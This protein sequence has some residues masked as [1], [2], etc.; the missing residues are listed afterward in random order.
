MRLLLSIAL[1]TAALVLAQVRAASAS[2]KLFQDQKCNKCHAISAFGIQKLSGGEEEADAGAGPP[3][4]SDIG[5]TH[6]AAFFGPYLMKETKDHDKLHKIKFK[7]TEA[8]L[9]EMAAWLATLKK[10]PKK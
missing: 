6:D 8:E 9:K 1:V 2:E 3:D 7:G 4:L 5:K 10:E